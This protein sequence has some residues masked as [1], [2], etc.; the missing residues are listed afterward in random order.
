MIDDIDK[1]TKEQLVEEFSKLQG[2]NTLECEIF[3]AAI[4]VKSA[5]DIEIAINDF[6]KTINMLGRQS[7][8]LSRRVFWLNVILVFATSIAA[9]ATLLIFFKKG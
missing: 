8:D 7:D 3:N 5:Q 6:N 9:V 4:R 1:K 2:H